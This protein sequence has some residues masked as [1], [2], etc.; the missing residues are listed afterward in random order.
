MNTE[1]ENE[2]SKEEWIEQVYQLLCVSQGPPEDENEV[3]NLRDWAESLAS[4]ET[5]FYS[6]G[7]SPK[8]AHDEEM[9][10]A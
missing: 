3:R 1:P 5:G 4:D 8:D 2:L 6:E 9:S 10:C 7:Y